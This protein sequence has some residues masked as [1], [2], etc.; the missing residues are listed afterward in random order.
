MM[1]SQYERF[2]K[3]VWNGFPSHGSLHSSVDAK[4]ISLYRIS[5]IV[6]SDQ[7]RNLY[8]SIFGLFHSLLISRPEGLPNAAS[9][10]CAAHR[11]NNEAASQWKGRVMN[12]LVVTM[13]VHN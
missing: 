7:D 2:G 8:M 9:S 3:N 12:F 1:F 4:K 5:L 6:N 10:L 13:A 11:Q